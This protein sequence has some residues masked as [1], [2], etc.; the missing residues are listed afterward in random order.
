MLRGYD[1]MHYAG[2]CYYAAADPSASGWMFTGGLALSAR[3][4][5]RLDRVPGFVFSNACESG[6]VAPRPGDV[7]SFAESLFGLGVKNL[8]ATAR[9]VGDVAAG[10]FARSLARTSCD[11][12]RRG[13]GGRRHRVGVRHAD[14][15]GE[16]LGP[17][18]PVVLRGEG[19][20]CSCARGLGDVGGERLDG[21]G[22]G[23]WIGRHGHVGTCF[24]AELA[25][26]GEVG[27]DD[28]KAG[29]EVLERLQ[30]EAVAVEAGDDVRDEPD[31]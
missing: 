26:R 6:R 2:H 7:P 24:L 5:E 10:A 25:Q 8:I 19:S 14:E 22:E 20:T 16:A 9:P 23:G 29:G 15:L 1:A 13:D 4:M 18:G 31:A 17:V 12:G 27:A 30:R 3:E 28:G 11:V 21:V